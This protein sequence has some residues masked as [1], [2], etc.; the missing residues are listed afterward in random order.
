MKHQALFSLKDKSKK[1]KK[2]NIVVCCKFLFCALRL[3]SGQQSVRSDE[4]LSEI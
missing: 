1:K 3:S 4:F 2:K